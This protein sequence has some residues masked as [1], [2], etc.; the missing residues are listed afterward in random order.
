MHYISIYISIYRH[1]YAY[2]YIGEQKT[3]THA[4]L[5]CVSGPFF[6]ARVQRWLSARRAITQPMQMHASEQV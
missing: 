2:T 4:L 6:R 5:T 3:R 1:T